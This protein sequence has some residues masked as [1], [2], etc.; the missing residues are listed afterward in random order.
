MLH[1]RRSENDHKSN[2]L[3]NPGS[4]FPRFLCLPNRSKFNAAETHDIR[5]NGVVNV[6]DRH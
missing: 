5:E 4:I 3:E 6:C 1:D 2:D